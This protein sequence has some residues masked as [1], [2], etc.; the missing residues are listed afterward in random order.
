M[1][2]LD[3]LVDSPGCRW[4]LL[5]VVVVELYR[6]VFDIQGFNYTIIICFS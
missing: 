2:H 1:E 4:L 3:H 5:F 6:T